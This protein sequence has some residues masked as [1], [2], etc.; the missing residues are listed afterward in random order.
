MIWED[1]YFDRVI[2]KVEFQNALSCAFSV[3]AET[4]VVSGDLQEITCIPKSTSIYCNSYKIMREHFI[5]TRVL[6]YLLNLPAPANDLKPLSIISRTLGCDV[7][8]G[9][10]SSDPDNWIKIS[11][12]EIGDIS[13]I[14]D[15][16]QEAELD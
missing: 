14:D 12:T 9:D 4:I 5:K 16:L 15:F 3:S 8:I 7:Y 13:C 10:Y 2:T 6:V 11:T 1:L